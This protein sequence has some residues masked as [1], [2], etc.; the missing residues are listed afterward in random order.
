M[1]AILSDG[2]HAYAGNVVLPPQGH[3]LRTKTTHALP[4]QGPMLLRL[5]FVNVGALCSEDTF[6]GL[7]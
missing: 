6:C 5:C 2:R 1:K 4:R 7:L 3:V